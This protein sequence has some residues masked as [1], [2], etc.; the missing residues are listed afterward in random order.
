MGGEDAVRN[1][2]NMKHRT[3]ALVRRIGH[4]EIAALAAIQDE[5]EVLSGLEFYPDA[6]RKAEMDQHD[7]IGK[8]PQA[9]HSRNDDLARE[10]I[11]LVDRTRCDNEVGTRSRVTEQD[12]SG[13]SLSRT[14]RVAGE[15]AHISANNAALAGAA[16]ALAA[17]ERNFQSGALRGVENRLAG[18]AGKTK[19][20]VGDSDGESH[21]VPG[22]RHMQAA[23]GRPLQRQCNERIYAR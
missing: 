20:R 15:S 11:G 18:L 23:K 3:V 2:A 13:D 5:A 22:R 19:I 14:E 16:H 1:A 4:R 8:A 17:R 6:R 21:Q 7:V 12:L 9:E 10:R